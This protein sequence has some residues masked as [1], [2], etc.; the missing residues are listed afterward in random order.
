M[1]QTSMKA[2]GGREASR[3][4]RSMSV[5][6]K[7]GLP[8]AIERSRGGESNAVIT[9][10]VKVPA[11]AA[12]PSPKLPPVASQPAVAPAST[13]GRPMTGREASF[14]RRKILVQGKAGL[15]KL[16]TDAKPATSLVEPKA[17]A[18]HSESVKAA[19][20]IMNPGRRAA[21]AM[22]SARARNG[23]GE[24]APAQPCGRVR[25]SQPLVYP[26]KVVDSKTYAGGKV[27]GVRIGRGT[28]MTGDEPGAVMP[29]T[30][31]QYIGTES[32]YAPR[33]GGVKVGAARTE[34]GLVVTGT[35]VRSKIKITGDESN[36]AI[37]IS[38]EADQEIADDLLSRDEQ[39][40]YSS[41]QFERQNNPHGHTV[42]GT[43][44]GRSIR[45]VGSRERKAE[46]VTEFSN[47]G[48]PISG[49]AVG[50]SLRVTGD[51]TGSC[52][53]ITGN[54]YLKP[55]SGQASCT[56]PASR[57]TADPR[58]A[59]GM[60]GRPDPVSGAKVAISDSWT[61]QRITGVDVEHNNSVT[62]DEPGVCAS[63]T[64]TAYVGPGQY[65]A[66]C[67]SNDVENAVQRT[68]PG[69]SAGNCVTGD[70]PLNVNHVTGTQRGAE[71]GITGTPYFR[72]DVEKDMNADV[73]NEIN[74]RFS[75][76]S[77]Q[78]E[79]HLQSD[80]STVNAPSAESRITG[81][82]ASGGSKITGNQEFHFNPRARVE[83]SDDRSRIT[84]EGRME[85]PAITGS[86]WSN[87]QNVTGTEGYIAA[88][89]NPSERAG[90]PH[91]FA[92]ATAFKDKGKNEPV[93][94]L[95]TGM[96]GMTD[97]TAAKVTLSGGAR[98]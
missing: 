38:G 2:T 46:N 55:A 97:G 50:T 1:Q 18:Q 87:N 66:Y 70:T 11:I 62:G 82:F 65:E 75:V 52:R 81:S 96:F 45:S 31:T 4:R 33:V 60:N 83:R 64:G 10:P 47:T 22:R 57:T 37:R 39:G 84:G 72:Q 58:S 27:T 89:R 12:V 20:G 93:R 28:N 7:T 19:A 78:R 80:V 24:T 95:V 5:R 3:E 26:H 40:A 92:N 9:A 42:F 36:P 23:R 25:N 35:Q 48:L 85:G 90:R 51:E 53:T 86:A 17:V 16:K 34:T 69:L 71:H 59:M 54:Q 13:G 30:G 77:P 44:L 63:I 68:A 32:G 14:A 98:G 43:N 56:S 8:P 15:Q 94:Q 73:I 91:G 41:M 49:T 61:R 88:E 74:S 6:G 29:V 76:H 21:Q 67:D 79:A